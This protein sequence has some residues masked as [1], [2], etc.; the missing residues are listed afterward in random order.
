[1]RNI[2]PLQKPFVTTYSYSTHVLSISADHKCFWEWFYSQHVQLMSTITPGNVILIEFCPHPFILPSPLLQS[3][4]IP[5]FLIQQLKD[6]ADIFSFVKQMLDQGYYMVLQIDEYGIPAFENYHKQHKLHPILIYGYDETEGLYIQDFFSFRKYSSAVIT[7]SELIQAFDLQHISS[8]K[9]ENGIAL[10]QLNPNASFILDLRQF[11]NLIGDYL[12]S[13]NTLQA[14]SLGI[15]YPR[16]KFGFNIYS[17]LDHAFDLLLENQQVYTLTRALHILSEH[18]KV[19]HASCSYLMSHSRIGEND[20]LLKR[21][22]ELHQ[23]AL[24]IRNLFLKYEITGQKQ[25]IVSTKRKL[26]ELA[27]KEQQAIHTY[28]EVVNAAIP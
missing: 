21:L 20:D 11:S 16:R 5:R 24:I 26:S 27:A 4:K 19:W 6:S 13:K 8:F 23:D 1:M 17:D 15:T 10:M 28:Q 14:S 3:W 12:Q 25:L 22:K 9:D 7:R 2:L 18:K